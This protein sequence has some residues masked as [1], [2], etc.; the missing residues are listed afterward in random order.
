MAWLASQTTPDIDNV[1]AA[2]AGY[3]HALKAVYWTAAVR[4]L[5][6]IKGTSNLGITFQ[7]G[8]GLHLEVLVDT[9]YGRKATDRRSILGG[10]MICG[11]A[12]VSWLS[13][14]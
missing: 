6:Y 13:R 14:R 2:V 3:C 10:V 12:A 11:L 1:T 7:R 8:R 4:L 9:E 5:E